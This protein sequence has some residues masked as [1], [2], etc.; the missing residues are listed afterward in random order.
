M[1]I[2][3]EYRRRIVSG[4]PRTALRASGYNSFGDM[5]RCAGMSDAV[6][7]NACYVEEAAALARQVAGSA[8]DVSGSIADIY[9]QW[10]PDSA[11][12][13]EPVAASGVTPLS[14]DPRVLTTI[15]RYQGRV[16]AV[17]PSASPGTGTGTGTGTAGSWLQENVNLPVVG[18]VPRWQ[19]GLGLGAVAV[20]ISLIVKALI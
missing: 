10:N 12:G 5:S 4:R 16:R 15:Q 3:G 2:V 19:A 18:A 11:I 13:N 1:A 9:G 17:T 8:S 14:I 6:A 20:G 7:R